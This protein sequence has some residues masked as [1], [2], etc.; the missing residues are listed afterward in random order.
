MPTHTILSIHLGPCLDQHTA[1]GLMTTRG[2]EMEWGGLVLRA[3]VA[4]GGES[5]G[6]LGEGANK[7]RKIEVTTTG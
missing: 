6:W 7:T 5:G 3:W 4:M 1:C 2:G